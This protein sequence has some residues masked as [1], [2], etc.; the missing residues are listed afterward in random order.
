MVLTKCV[1]T[2]PTL[3]VI[4][5]VFAHNSPSS[6]RTTSTL[7]TTNPAIRYHV[8]FLYEMCH[9]NSCHFSPD[10]PLCIVSLMFTHIFNLFSWTCSAFHAIQWGYVSI[11]SFQ[12]ISKKWRH[13]FYI[14]EVSISGCQYR[15]CDTYMTFS[16]IGCLVTG[17]FLKISR[18]EIMKS[19]KISDYR[20]HH[21]PA[22][23]QCGY[24]SRISNMKYRY[25]Y[26]VLSIL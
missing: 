25:R 2:I 11:L 24:K 12:Y 14:W 17:N 21:F 13:F 10:K 20:I 22:V 19:R 3:P 9:V 7:W 4:F 15:F 26:I 23:V 1:S 16:C 18:F 8:D 6:E 5:W